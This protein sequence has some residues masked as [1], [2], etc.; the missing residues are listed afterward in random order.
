MKECIV[1]QHELKKC[2][3]CSVMQEH[4]LPFTNM[5]D[6]AYRGF[7][8]DIEMYNE[9]G[10]FCYFFHPDRNKISEETADKLEESMKKLHEA[11]DNLIAAQNQII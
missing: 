11:I 7:L 6:P 3:K 10:E 5:L 8:P 4:I 9:N 1:C 2:D